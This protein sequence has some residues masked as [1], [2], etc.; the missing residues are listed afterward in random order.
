M[1]LL[2]FFNTSRRGHQRSRFLKKHMAI[3]IKNRHMAIHLIE[4]NKTYWHVGREKY[5]I[6]RI[7]KRNTVY[8]NEG[9]SLFDTFEDAQSYLLSILKAE[10]AQAIADISRL[11]IELTAIETKIRIINTSSEQDYE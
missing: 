1:R 8:M 6:T 3:T 11:S 2:I 5:T 7:K 4:T 9:D 10:H